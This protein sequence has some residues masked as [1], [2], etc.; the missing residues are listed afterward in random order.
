MQ[1][2]YR[3]SNGVLGKMTGGFLSVGSDETV[4]SHALY[5]GKKKFI[6]AL[7]DVC[8]RNAILRMFRVS[9]CDFFNE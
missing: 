4:T 3:R 9:Q 6:Q 1:I 8:A 5:R 2:L 7:F